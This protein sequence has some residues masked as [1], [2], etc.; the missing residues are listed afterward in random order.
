MAFF[1]NTYPL[2]MPIGVP[3]RI[4]D[5]GF[6]NTLSPMCLENIPAAVGVMKPLNLDYAIMLPRN[7]AGALTLSANFVTGNI[8]NITL[9]GVAITP[10]AYDT[11]GTT[12]ATLQA[13]ADALKQIP[14]VQ[15][16]TVGG[17]GDLVIT[18]VSVPG[19]ATDFTVNTVTGG[20]SQPTLTPA[21]NQSG[22][23]FGVTQSIYNKMNAW[24]PDTGPNLTLSSGMPSPY[25]T[26]QV[27]P[28]LTQGRIYVVPE[29][30]VVS[31]S[32]V[33]MRIV[34]S[35]GNTQ[36]GAFRSDSD[37]GNAVLIP[38]TSAIW[39]EGNGTIGGIAVLELNIP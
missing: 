28:T 24:I 2:N 10:I 11:Y 29:N 21:E 12:P 39:R 19:T 34:A 15:S 35:G 13:I 7:N 3:G 26:G 31:N 38:A 30:L 17:L 36:L 25:Y 1:Q 22:T 5:C 14:S 18:V 9:N 16:A 6:K 20:A 37:G 32:P 23:F 4:A 27:A 33:Y 8:I